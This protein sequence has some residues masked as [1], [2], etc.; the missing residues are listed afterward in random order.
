MSCW[1]L[2][3]SD[4]LSWGNRDSV[5]HEVL[6]QTSVEHSEALKLSGQQSTKSWNVCST[7]P[8]SLEAN[9]PALCQV[10]KW[11]QC[12]KANGNDVG[13][14]RIQMER[15]RSMQNT[16][17]CWN[18]VSHIA[19]LNIGFPSLWSKDAWIYIKN[20]I[21]NRNHFKC[22]YMERVL[23][24]SCGIVLLVINFKLIFSI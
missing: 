3:L 18:I 8:I 1:V 15:E 17:S 14:I 7:I 4:H 23:L 24:M 10:L 19:G 13:K 22:F 21:K 9:P 11:P 2:H 6:Y 20:R 5:I 16:T 12:M